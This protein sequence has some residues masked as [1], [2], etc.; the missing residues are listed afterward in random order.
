MAPP[1]SPDRR[2][3][4]RPRS[5]GR[6]KQESFDAE[7]VNAEMVEKLRWNALRTRIGMKGPVP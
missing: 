3:I 1:D 6:G 5:E 4:R 2:S 7:V